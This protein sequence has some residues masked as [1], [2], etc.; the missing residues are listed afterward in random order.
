LA[1]VREGALAAI[2]GNVDGRLLGIV[3]D[4]FD[5][6]LAERQGAEV[7]ESVDVRFFEV[8]EERLVAIL[9]LALERGMVFGPSH[10]A[11]LGGLLVQFPEFDDRSWTESDLIVER[12]EGVGA[13]GGRVVAVGGERHFD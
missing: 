1:V 11:T 12:L 9:F 2:S 13:I 8:V 7:T 4:V 10:L 3:D 6:R 5:A